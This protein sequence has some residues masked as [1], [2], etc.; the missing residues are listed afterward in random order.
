VPTFPDVLSVEQQ[1]LLDRLASLSAGA[2]EQAAAGAIRTW[3]HT[4]QAWDRSR[5]SA[6]APGS[7]G[8]R[9]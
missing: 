2:D 8:G 6:A 4:V 5:P 3:R 9:P 7:A 1:S